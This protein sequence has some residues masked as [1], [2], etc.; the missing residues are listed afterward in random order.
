MKRSLFLTTWL[1]LILL[2]SVAITI[3]SLTY[4]PII[5]LTKNYISIFGIAAGFVQIY[6]IVQLFMWKKIGVTLYLSSAVIIFLVTAIN[7]LNI[8]SN[9]I[10]VSESLLFVLGVNVIVLGILYLAMRPVWKSFK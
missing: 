5:S 6:A 4:L 8:I 9:I 3:D 1:V 10:I 2:F 7:E